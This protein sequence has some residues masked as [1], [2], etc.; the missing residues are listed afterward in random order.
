MQFVGMRSLKLYILLVI[1]T[2]FAGCERI[3][4][5]SSLQGKEIKLFARMGVHL[6]ASQQTKGDGVI[7]SSTNR[8]FDIGIIRGDLSS[9]NSAYFSGASH[10]TATVG[11]PADN[12]FLR[13]VSHFST[14][15]FFKNSTDKVVYAGWYPK[16]GA[17]YDSSNNKV[18]FSIPDTGDSD[19]MYSSITKGTMSSGFDV[20]QFNHALSLFRI[21]VYKSTNLNWGN[22]TS[23][24]LTGLPDV[25]TVTIPNSDADA[26]H[27]VQY[28]NSSDKPLSM[29]E[30]LS[31]TIPTGFENKLF[32]K[33]WIAAPAELPDLTDSKADEIKML[34]VSVTTDGTVPGAADT[35]E[36]P[37][38]RNFK[39]GYVYDI[40]LRF[41][42]SGVVNAEVVV[43]EWE[44]EDDIYSD[45][46]VSN[47]FFNL[48]A[49]EKANCYIVS[50]ANFSY[51]FDATVKGNGVIGPLALE[52]SMLEINPDSVRIVWIDDAVKNDFQ[53]ETNKIVQGKVLFTVKGN[54]DKDIKTL[55]SEGNVLL[56]VYDKNGS[57]LWTWHIWITDK[58]QKQNYTKG[59]IALDRNLGAIAPAPENGTSN[60]MKGLFY[61]WGRPT[62]FRLTTDSTKVDATKVNVKVTPDIAVANPEKFYGSDAALD[63]YDWIDNTNFMSVNNLWGYGTQEHEQPVKTI[64][65]PCP[66]GYHVPYARNWE[67]LDQYWVDSLKKNQWNSLAGIHFRIEDN[68]IWYPFQGY[69]KKD[70]TYSPGHVHLHNDG[71]VEYDEETPILEIW[72]SLINTQHNSPYRFLFTKDYGS[73]LSDA[74][75]NRS[76]GLAVRCVSDNT[77]DVVKD[78]SA[79]QTANCYMVHEDGYYK[80]KAT[81]RGNGVGSLLPLGGTTTAEI[82]GGLSTEIPH[83]HI[84]KVDILW[85]QGDFTIEEDF[86][87]SE[88]K[89]DGSPKNLCLSLL[90]NGQICEDGYAS[91]RISGFSKGNVVLAAYDGN[92]ILWTWHIWLTDKP[93]D[94]ISGNYT[95]MDRFLGATFAPEFPN[96]SLPTTPSS[97]NWG[98]GEQQATL[99]FYYQWGRKD[100]LIGPPPPDDDDDDNENSSSGA[101][102]ASS[103]WWEKTANGWNYR[104]TI[105][106]KAKASIPDVVQ[107]PTAFYKSTST[108]GATS[109]QWFPDSFADSYTNVALWGYAV[110]DYSK[111]GQTFSKTMHDPCPPGYRT[112]FHFSWRYDSNYKY[113]EG[114]LGE[115]TTTLTSN[116]KNWGGGGIVTNK[117]HFENMWFPFAGYRDPLTGACVNVGSHGYMNTG[118]PMGQYNTR[119]F[120]YNEDQTGQYAGQHGSAYGKMVRCMKE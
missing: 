115:Q 2:V 114:D 67:N 119:S 13:N 118:M 116:E 84:S 27:T 48:S 96:G 106:V 117:N 59:Y 100:P 43:G 23:V 97:I 66:A 93:E 50:S 68:D 74:Y 58:P 51:C 52:S 20:M 30:T 44:F 39:P 34:N 80:F 53:L 5:I 9:S 49:N 98:Y 63:A 70:G 86:D 4:D 37:I 72:S 33:E 3:D 112:P 8:S 36:V 105:D 1:C 47:M 41:S 11:T 99:G 65:D 14:P 35:L 94:K 88:L 57:C 104:T 15:Q 85:W 109:S 87:S 12:M 38:A 113:A 16:D 61:Q 71:K 89:A 110:A 18:T 31:E 40:V 29:T 32:I 21:H 62:P 10:M 60:G 81:V 64:Y 73:M 56:G 107:D 75:T 45:V 120:W 55:N 42:D 108:Q 77:E 83:G 82:N 91:F 7:S 90:D 24:S 95:K 46:E 54:G 22:V 79:S 111:E 6:T 28:S 17:S 76:R 78:L 25:C 19:I 101:T 103:G 102:V 69:L 92:T 26:N